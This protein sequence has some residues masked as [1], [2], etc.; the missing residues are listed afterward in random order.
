MIVGCDLVERQ[1]PDPC[2]I[3]Y[4]MDEIG[5]T[6]KDETWMIGDSVTDIKAGKNAGVN[7]AVVAWGA[8]EGRRELEKLGA[9]RII[10]NPCEFLTF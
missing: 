2:G 5:I 7:T 9:D 4:I 8:T 3:H 1:K 10:S 6:A